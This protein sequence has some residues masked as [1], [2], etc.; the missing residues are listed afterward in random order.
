[1]EET[2]QQ[3]YVDDHGE[4][5]I[6]PMAMAAGG[7]RCSCSCNAASVLRGGGGDHLLSSG[8]VTPEDIGSHERRA[9]YQV[10]HP[11]RS[12]SCGEET[13]VQQARQGFASAAE[14]LG[15]GRAQFQVCHSQISLALIFG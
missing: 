4:D 6:P 12:R 8:P 9:A 3:R 13:G 10:L 2:Q 7:Q 11:P 15:H 14:G 5:I 1:M